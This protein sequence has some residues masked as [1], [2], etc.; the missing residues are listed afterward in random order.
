MNPEP[1]IHWGMNCVLC[2]VSVCLARGIAITNKSQIVSAYNSRRRRCV[3]RCAAVE[4]KY[5]HSTRYARCM[6]SHRDERAVTIVKIVGARTG[7]NSSVATSRCSVQV[8]RLLAPLFVSGRPNRNV[9]HGESS[10]SLSS[11][12]ICWME[13]GGGDAGVCI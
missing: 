6:F 3:V 8:Y 12:V 10:V 4:Q 9:V 7:V 13:V 1:A 5:P 11:T 2:I